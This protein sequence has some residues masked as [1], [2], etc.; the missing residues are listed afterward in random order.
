MDV[1]CIDLGKYS[2]KFLSGR[3]ERKEFICDDVMEEIVSEH[4]L[5]ATDEN[6]DPSE[7]LLEVQIELIRNFLENN[8]HIE[9]F[10]I[11]LPNEFTTTRF[12][13]VPV[14]SR[15]KAEQILP[16]QLEDELPFSL[17]DAHLAN[18]FI[19][20]KDALYVIS[21]ITKKE[22]FNKLFF[23]LG[24]N[25]IPAEGIVSEESVFQN[26]VAQ[27]D[28]GDEVAILDI[29]H[30]ETKCYMFHDKLLVD[31]Q[32]S[33]LAGSVIDEVI[34]ETY[35]I[36]NEEAI[37]FK[38]QNS[39][40]LTDDQI[41]SVNKEQRDFALLMKRIF[42]TLVNDFKRWK[43]GYRL[44]TGKNITKVYI[45]GGTT[46]IKNIENFL[47]Q[48]FEISVTPLNALER[49]SISDLGLRKNELNILNKSFFLSSLFTNKKSVSD[50]VS[51]DYSSTIEGIIPLHSISFMGIRSLLVASLLLA[52][53]IL[54]GVNLEKGIRFITREINPVLKNP[55]LGISNR[56]R[57]SFRK[58]PQRV[59][60]F[61][62]N[63]QRQLKSEI[64]TL[65]Q[66]SQINAL[67]PLSNL[68][69]VIE[70]AD[71]ITIRS[72]ETRN[73]QVL[74][75]AYSDQIDLLEKLK[76]SL[77][78]QSYDNLSIDLID[79]QKLLKASYVFTE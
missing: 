36:S 22:I 19:P 54:E 9:K 23:K 73:N 28:L 49:T 64:E 2:V 27:E 66:V 56:L 21:S 57:N 34:Q 62:K 3:I 72:F 6:A 70:K 20:Q 71:A 45:C 67:A 41:E 25:N 37:I 65:K 55:Q 11:N 29:G 69:D 40:F 50:F 46:N 17:V 10:V 48:S 38:H 1:L 16:F 30:A 68:S 59:L 63:N 58:S 53:F 47:T 13:T 15:K 18:L 8:P 14:K 7:D 4:L 79:S 74:F 26:I 32:T 61:I 76:N 33:F 31:T 78:A 35:N 39:F 43:V 42:Q 52:V 24:E 77:E 5:P 12:L 75:T 44:K 60:S 51:G